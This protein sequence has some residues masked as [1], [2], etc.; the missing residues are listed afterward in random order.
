MCIKSLA[1]HRG[2]FSLAKTILPVD[3]LV[4]LCAVRADALRTD[5]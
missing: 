3:G 4:A 5:I 1:P 2:S